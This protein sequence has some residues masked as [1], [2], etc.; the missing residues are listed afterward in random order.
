M[1]NAITSI[2]RFLG[3]LPSLYVYAALAVGSAILWL[4]HQV[5]TRDNR[6]RAEVAAQASADSARA[7]VAIRDSLQ[8]AASEAI[9]REQARADSIATASRAQASQAIRRWRVLRD[10]LKAAGSTAYDGPIGA[11][12]TAITF[13]AVAL[14][15]C[16]KARTVAD[17][18][19]E[20]ERRD[21]ARIADERDSA[22]NRLVT[23]KP[24]TPQAPSKVK[25]VRRVIIAGA[26][27]LLGGLL[28]R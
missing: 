22:N 28:W 12:D 23:P 11:A 17:S 13:C 25:R 2:R 7:V 10:S 24:E 21:K 4:G 14:A 16:E 27:G 6:I 19:L 18:A 26:L 1:K 15:D 8:R 20:S 3:G 5:E 9:A